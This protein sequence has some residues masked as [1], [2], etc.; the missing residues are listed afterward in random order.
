MDCDD[1]SDFSHP[2]TYYY[3]AAFRYLIIFILLTLWCITMKYVLLF[4]FQSVK[5]FRNKRISFNLTISLVGSIKFTV[6][7]F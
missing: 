4:K 1:L 5:G 6:E 3:G 7:F 2:N